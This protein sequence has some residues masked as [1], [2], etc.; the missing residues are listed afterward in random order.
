MKEYGL[1]GRRSVDIDPRECASPSAGTYDDQ[2]L[3]T[4]S[5]TTPV[6]K[7]KQWVQFDL[8]QKKYADQWAQLHRESAVKEASTA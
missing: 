1:A 8:Q 5:T 4:C 7:K 3:W 2:V 6:K